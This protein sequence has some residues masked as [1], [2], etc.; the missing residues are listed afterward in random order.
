MKDLQI[1]QKFVED[2]G[3]FGV[4]CLLMMYHSNSTWT[5][6]LPNYLFL[7]NLWVST[8]HTYWSGGEAAG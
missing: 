2:L 3:V 7:M 6:L 4:G 1:V 5:S 8:G